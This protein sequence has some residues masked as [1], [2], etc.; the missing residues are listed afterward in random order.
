LRVTLTWIAPYGV[1]ADSPVKERVAVEPAG[2]E[3]VTDEADDEEGAA[4]PCAEPPA[5]PA[6]DAVGEP[7]TAPACTGAV[8]GAGCLRASS[9]TMAETVAAVQSAI[10]RSGCFFFTVL[11]HSHFEGLVMDT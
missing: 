2:E 7:A 3:L 4:E 11:T 10:R 5:E 1:V 9:A 8:P 6:A